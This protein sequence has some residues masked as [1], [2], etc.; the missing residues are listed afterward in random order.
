M[1]HASVST[2]DTRSMSHEEELRESVWSDMT[3]INM[4]DKEYIKAQKDMLDTYDLEKLIVY[5]SVALNHLDFIKDDTIGILDTGTKDKIRREAYTRFLPILTKVNELLT[6]KFERPD[7][8]HEELP[9][10]LFLAGGRKHRKSR[11][12][13]KSRKHR[14]SRISRKSR[15]YKRKH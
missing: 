9:E 2:P 12:P 11:K 13:R 7:L 5:K 4:T 8:S 1:S 15:R 10:E 6:K 3:N 14:K